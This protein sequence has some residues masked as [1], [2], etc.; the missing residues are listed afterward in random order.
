M[1]QRI[2]ILII[3]TCMGKA[4]GQVNYI[5]LPIQG[6][7]PGTVDEEI[8]MECMVISTEEDTLWRES[9]T[10]VELDE[11]GMFHFFL[12]TGVYMAGI[13]PSFELMDWS[14][15]D[16]FELYRADGDRVLIGAYAITAVPYAFESKTV[17]TVLELTD[18]EDTPE[19]I[20]DSGRLF[21]FNGTTF[22]W[23]DDQ[24]YDSDFAYM[25]DAVSYSDTVWLALN[26]AFADSAQ[27]AVLAGSVQYAHQIN[28]VSFADSSTIADTAAVGWFS[29]GNWLLDG[30]TGMVD[31]NFVGTTTTD[32]LVMRT[33][34]I[35]RLVLADS[36]VHN[37]FPGIG[38]RNQSNRGFLATPNTLS[39]PTLFDNSYL[40]YDG[41]QHLFHAGSSDLSVDTL[42]GPY[43]FAFGENVGTNGPYSTVFGQNT[44][45]DTAIF[46]GTTPYAAVS[47]FALGRD[48]RVTHMGV[49]I[50]DSA[51]AGY[52]RN[53]AIGRKVIATNQSSG[54]ALGNNVLVT[55]ATAWAAGRNLTADG[56]FSTA[57]GSNASSGD[58]NGSFVYGDF[59][60]TDTVANTAINQFMVRAAGGFIFYS[61]TDLTMGVELLPGAG[62]WSMISDRH[63]KRNIEVLQSLNYR[64]VYDSL[65]IYS[66]NYIGNSTAHIGPMAQDFYTLFDVGEKPYLINMIDSDGVTFMGIKMLRESL[67]AINLEAT[68]NAVE[69]ELENEQEALDDLE[70]RINTLY[71]EL[72]NH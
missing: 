27:Y 23:S 35:P 33:N 64:S 45:G 7:I 42:R 38:F 43:S 5:G 67:D 50:G 60:T 40:Y 59:S 31:T 21:S 63:K 68:E 20:P 70:K 3:M 10:A 12:G 2:L 25:A 36:S 18:L 61:T 22:I 16:R 53:V 8:D 56:N 37:N 39:G 54:I 62:S 44:F 1:H 9:Q 51:I 65:S 58:F 71:E 66:W 13:Y 28:A 34:N 46:A 4:F 72:D 48:C 52:Y 17:E 57:M 32:S 26:D 15:V 41:E 6:Q 29:N 30:N 47:S 24:L 55:G 19:I 11:A 14:L 69:E 49:A